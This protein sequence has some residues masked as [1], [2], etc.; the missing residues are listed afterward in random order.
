MRPLPLAAEPPPAAEDAPPPPRGTRLDT[1]TRGA[2]PAPA[3]ASLDEAEGA[4]PLPHPVDLATLDPW[5]DWSALPRGTLRGG[6]DRDVLHG[7]P[8]PHPLL[9]PLPLLSLASPGAAHLHAA[10]TPPHCAMWARGAL[11]EGV[12]RVP[13]PTVEAAWSALLNERLFPL[14]T[15]SA[16]RFAA[17]RKRG[18]R[19]AIAGAGAL[20][21][22]ALAAPLVA[23]GLVGRALLRGLR[24]GGAR[25][26]AAAARA[27][28]AAPRPRAVTAKPKAPP[29]SPPRPRRALPPQAAGASTA[30]GGETGMGEGG[31]ATAAAA[32]GAARGTERTAASPRARAAAAAVD[33]FVDASR[34]VAARSGAQTTFFARGKIVLSEIC[35]L[36]SSLSGG[37][38]GLGLGGGAGWAH[39]PPALPDVDGAAADHAA[40][41]LDN[42]AAGALEADGVGGGGGARRRSSL[43]SGSAAASPPRRGW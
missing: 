29:P 17:L 41:V 6:E 10:W 2:A 18:G 7:A 24:R 8:L 9:L 36:L 27:G 33:R 26:G 4:P 40:R 12:V 3:P 32:D 25:R 37:G 34:A 43:R 16:R 39:P 15:A 38:G 23:C 28:G 42:L 21:L 30:E 1:S 19:A 13:A 31:A 20:L 35:A 22:F 14:V 11:E 5:A